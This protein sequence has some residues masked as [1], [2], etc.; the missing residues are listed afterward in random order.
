MITV[1]AR[2]FRWRLSLMNAVAA[3]A[4]SLLFPQHAG[5]PTEAALFGGVALLAAGSSALNQ[6]LERDLDLLMKRTC[7]RPL[8]KGQL[9]PGTVAWTGAGC[10]VAGLVMLAA[11]GGAVPALIGAAV[12]AWYLAV[13]TPLKRRTPLSLLAGALCGAATPVIGWTCAGGTA[14]DFPI[15]LLSTLLYLWQ[16]PH[17]WLLQ[18]RHID[19]YR[20]AGLAILDLFESRVPPPLLIMLWSTAVIAVVMMFPLFGI[21]AD[22]RALSGALFT[23]PLL[24]TL[25]RRHERALYAYLNLFPLLVAATLWNR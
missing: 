9:A 20:R 11:V 25:S 8:P 15:L 6:Y 7:E 16:V 22:G 14:F 12:I 3:A 23:L 10:I 18:R 21:V 2:L 1:L 24:L 4:G 19:D 5:W 13:Y 17:F